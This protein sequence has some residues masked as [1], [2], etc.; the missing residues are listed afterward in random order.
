M[1][2]AIIQI[3]PEL[4]SEM[5]IEGR[6]IHL[7]VENGLPE[8]VKFINGRYIIDAFGCTVIQ[9]IYESEEFEDISEGGVVPILKPAMFTRMECGEAVEEASPDCSCGRPG[10]VYHGGIIYCEDC[11]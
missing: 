4:L 11:I 1:K 5:L 3:T 8:D 7:K 6:E 2:R 9:L 10:S